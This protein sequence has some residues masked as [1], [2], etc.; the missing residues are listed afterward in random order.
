[1]LHALCR[2][3]VDERID[4]CDV[5]VAELPLRGLVRAPAN[6]LPNPAELGIGQGAE[7]L[8]TARAVQAEGIE[9]EAVPVATITNMQTGEALR[10]RLRARR[11]TWPLPDA[12]RLL[13]ACGLRVAQRGINLIRIRLRDT[14]QT[15]FH[16]V[17]I[18]ILRVILQPIPLEVLHPM[19]L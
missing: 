5:V 19:R 3:G 14:E 17:R 13:L 16:L 10:Q 9:I 15:E 18:G 12:V 2:R 11:A 6:L 1:D 7:E 8:I 4:L